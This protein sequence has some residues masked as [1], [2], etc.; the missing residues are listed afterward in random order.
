MF[1]IYG[2]GLGVSVATATAVVTSDILS[3]TIHYTIDSMTNTLIYMSQSN[4]NTSIN[5]YHNE[6]VSLDIEFKLKSI[7][8]WVQELDKNKDNQNNTENKIQ[9]SKTY[10]TILNG[11]KD[12]CL[13]LNKEIQSINEKIKYHQTKWFHSY[14]TLMVDDEIN[15]IKQLNK[16][17]NER[18]YLFILKD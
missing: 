7:Q 11:V 1:G 12:V 5:K 10:H 2:L 18:L 9:M 6:L 15:R 17:L 4:E 8:I 14:R 16:I 3:K 13:D